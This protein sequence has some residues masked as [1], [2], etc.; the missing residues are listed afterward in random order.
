M[1]HLVLQRKSANDLHRLWGFLSLYLVTAS[2]LFLAAISLPYDFH[3]CLY[4][5]RLYPYFVSGRIISGT[6]LPFALLYT[7]GLEV[8]F[9]RVRPCIHPARP[10]AAIMP[11]TTVSDVIVVM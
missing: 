7:S 11:S 9:M 3:D 8:L 2:A 6:L 4:P 5:S 1:V 10:L